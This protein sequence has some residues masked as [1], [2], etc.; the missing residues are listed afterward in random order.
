MRLRAAFLCLAI[1]CLAMTPAE[2]QRLA[3]QRGAFDAQHDRAAESSEGLNVLFGRD[4]ERAGVSM[5]SV[6]E[7]YESAYA[8]ATAQKPWW[9]K[10]PAGTPWFILLITIAGAAVKKL[11]G[12]AIEKGVKK[13]ATAVYE[14]IAGVRVFRGLALR[15]Y[16]EAL[17][18]RYRKITIPFSSDVELE[19]RDA[20]IPLKVKG[21]STSD[22]V[23]ALSEIDHHRRLVILGAPGSGKSMLLRNLAFAYAD[24]RMRLSE[25]IIPVIL[26][27]SRMNESKVDVV[28]E[29]VLAF[30]RNNFPNADGFV[31]TAIANGTLLLLLDGLDEVNSEQRK[32][33]VQQIDDLV[34]GPAQ[35][36]V[37][38]TCRTLVYE[39]QFSASI[40]KVLEVVDFNDQQMMAFLRPWQKYMPESKSTGELLQTLRDRPPIMLV[41]RNPLM[42]TIVAYLY[43]DTEDFQLP[44][45]RADFY[46]QAVDLLLR[47]WKVD[48]NNY[49]GPDK[50]A[51]LEHLARHVQQ[52]TGSEDDRRSIDRQSLIR[53]VSEVL[54]SLN[55][56]PEA[57]LPMVNEIVERS[58]LLMWIDGGARCQFVHLTMQEFFAASALK[59]EELGLVDLYRADPNAWREVV[60]LWCGLGQNSTSFITAIRAFD[61]AMAFECLADAQIVDQEVAESIIEQQSAVFHE[62]VQAFAAVASDARPRGAA[63]FKFLESR[64]RPGYLTPI[65][66]AAAT[67]L[68][69]TNLKRAAE[70]LAQAFSRDPPFRPM[71]V[72]LGDIAVDSVM[73][74]VAV[75]EDAIDVLREIGTPDAAVAICNTFLWSITSSH[76][77]AAAK[78][79]A[80]MFRSPA[81][82]EALG[83]EIEILPERK[84][85][86]L[87]PWLW[88]PFIDDPSEKIGLIASFIVEMLGESVMRAPLP[89]MDSRIALALCF[90]LARTKPNGLDFDFAINSLPDGKRDPVRAIVTKANATQRNWEG[91]RRPEKYDFR[92]SAEHWTLLVIQGLLTLC[93][94]VGIGR[95]LMTTRDAKSVV[96]LIVV[97]LSIGAGWYF[98]WRGIDEGP[99]DRFVAETW[100]GFAIAPLVV[101]LA[102]ILLIARE[103]QSRDA[104]PLAKFASG[105]LFTPAIFVFTFAEARYRLGND[106]AHWLI[107]IVLALVTVTVGI[108][109]LRIIRA[110][111]PLLPLLQGGSKLARFGLG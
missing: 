73:R 41:A 47:K 46:D 9:K 65:R 17:A 23:D 79:L 99:E 21:T 89:E 71:L 7:A 16:R 49:V 19:M 53:V 63:V 84:A 32:R 35:C 69:L 62:Q 95:L 10:L 70:V 45:S 91:L 38:I 12:E 34:T 55:Y 44:R 90:W 74:W 40:P 3:R 15:K 67:A 103:L 88:T 26:E 20:Y 66:L 98:S 58:G 25:P 108:A 109:L 76:R 39:D 80:V 31:R 8:A 30:E 54:P 36:R 64:L 18:K 72:R 81:V 93:A 110:R 60:K 83:A 100:L 96:G 24:S 102:I 101:I 86:V 5:L 94:T 85:A 92:L 61:P 1:V 77:Y 111:N 48:K 97:L 107:G 87:A 51:V 42:L 105:L 28:G 4:A 106:H 33:V 59:N 37:V 13:I 6:K 11:F 68:S 29:V 27:L 2:L 82:V 104:R 52:S 50:R 22:Q 78:A 75:P 56:K 57:A 14:R 43:T